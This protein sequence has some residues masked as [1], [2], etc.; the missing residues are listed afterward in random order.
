MT[1]GFS[2][3]LRAELAKLDDADILHLLSE[4]I[5]PSH[6][7]PI[8]FTNEAMYDAMIHIDSAYCDAYAAMREIAD[9]PDPEDAYDPAAEHALTASQLGIATGRRAG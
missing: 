2:P 3:T 1:Q 9:E 6:K 7:G 5:Q 4:I 8:S